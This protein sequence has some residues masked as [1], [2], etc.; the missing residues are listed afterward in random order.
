MVMLEFSIF[1]IDKGASLS[2]YVSRCLDIVDKSGVPYK[3]N[4][5]GTVLEGDWD[6]VFGVVKSC[7]DELSKDCDRI[8]VTMKVDARKDRKGALDGKIK[9][10]EGKLGRELNK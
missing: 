3:I 9:S 8:E 4:P 2:P 1:P 6:T 10:I 5:M 7:Y